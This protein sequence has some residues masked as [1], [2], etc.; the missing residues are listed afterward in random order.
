LYQRY[1]ESATNPTIACFQGDLIEIP[2]M[3]E[4]H[5]RELE[6]QY[7]DPAERAAR[8]HGEFTF[9]EGRVW[10]EY[11]DHNLIDP[12]PIPRDWPIYVILDPH[13][14]KATG[15][16]AVAENPQGIGYVFWE[17]EIKGDVHYICER[18]K[19]GLAGKYVTTWL[20]DPSSRQSA[21]IYGKGRLIDEFRVDIPQ[22]LEANNDRELGW[23]AVRKR[24]KNN[25]PAGPKLFIFRSCPKTHFQ[26]Q[27][28][29]WKPPMA[30]GEHRNKPEVVKRNDELC[31]CIRYYCMHTRMAQL[32]GESFDGF[33][34]GMLANG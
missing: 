10:K 8:V 22:V 29:S 5:I 13:P 16:L 34:I 20:I 27:N 24:V 28:Y 17:D 23:E 14:E 21:G 18:I 4:E 2:G 7:E 33:Q 19:A 12:F 31:D 15:V 26:M 1:I 9:Q 6:K 11:G 25:P 30:S 3:T 32:G